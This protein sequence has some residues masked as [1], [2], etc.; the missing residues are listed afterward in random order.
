MEILISNLPHD[1]SI[2]ELRRL[3]GPETHD[4]C[5]QLVLRSSGAESWCHARVRLGD[6]AAQRRLV[7]RLHGFE[8]AG[9]TVTA[10]VFVQRHA[11]NDRRAPWWRAMP[12]HGVERRRGE[13]RRG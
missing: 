10:R 8:Y 5:Y 1:I 6:E 12:W 11:H 4:A 9:R 2:Q 7:E 13:R 3:A